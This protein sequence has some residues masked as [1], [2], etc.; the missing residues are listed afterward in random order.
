MIKTPEFLP[1]KITLGEDVFIAPGATVVGQVSLGARVS[2]WYQAV[3]RGDLAAIKIGDETN[4]QDGSVLHVDRRLP[5]RLGRRV[6]VGHRA[7]IHGA[8]IADEC[9]IGMGAI[10]LSGAVIGTHSIVG[11][12]AVVTEGMEIPPRSLVLGIPG[13]VV[14]TMP[15]GIAARIQAN[16][17]DYVA[18]AA[19]A[20][21]ALRG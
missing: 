17:A 1:T 3:L 5:V 19:A 18:A 4:I 16:A 10:V 7:V 15:S 11:A 21:A 2:V 6:V 9:L 14:R 13:K 20:R 12:G 8:T